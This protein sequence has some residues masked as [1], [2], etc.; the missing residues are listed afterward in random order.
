MKITVTDWCFNEIVFKGINGFIPWGKTIL[1]KGNEIEVFSAIECEV[2][3]ETDKAIQ[4]SFP[5]SVTDNRCNIVRTF[6][7]WKVWIPKK[8][9]LC[10]EKET[11]YNYEFLTFCDFGIYSRLRAEDLLP[12]YEE[13]GYTIKKRW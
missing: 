2:I 10:S 11:N 4:I 13:D 12:S 6:D 5:Y 7:S 1:C 8:C 9:V 3:R